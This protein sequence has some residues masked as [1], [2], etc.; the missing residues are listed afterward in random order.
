MPDIR[1]ILNSLDEV[2]R[3]LWSQVRTEMRRSYMTAHNS[4]LGL[5][6]WDPADDAFTDLI[7]IK[8][9]LLFDRSG[10]F[11]STSDVIGR[12][13]EQS[14]EQSINS[15]FNKMSKASTTLQKV[16]KQGNNGVW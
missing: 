4:I 11:N 16:A 2:D 15:Q 13:D 9:A 5:P 3:R 10:R 7:D 12:D 6:A 8:I 1:E 14:I